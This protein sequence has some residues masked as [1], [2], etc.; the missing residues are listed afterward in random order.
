VRDGPTTA[1]GAAGKEAPALVAVGTYA[2]LLAWNEHIYQFLLLSSK[3]SMIVPV[4]LAQ[5]LNSDDA[6]SN[7]MMATASISRH[8][9]KA[10]CGNREHLGT[11]RIWKG[12]RDRLPVFR[13]SL[14][15]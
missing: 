11:Q 14:K 9:S 8:T 5:F 10:T 4:A 2:L 12:I 6:P 15:R 7:Y 1:A 13:P 3:K